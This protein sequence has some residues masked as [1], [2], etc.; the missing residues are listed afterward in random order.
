[1]ELKTTFIFT[2]F[3]NTKHQHCHCTGK[4][5]RKLT[6]TEFPSSG[7][8]LWHGNKGVVSAKKRK[9]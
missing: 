6:L 9:K 4:I 7:H 1:M 8:I 2:L 3:Q 5:P